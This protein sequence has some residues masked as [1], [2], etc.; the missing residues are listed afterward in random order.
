MLYKISIACLTAARSLRSP[1]WPALLSTVPWRQL[2]HSPGS[3]SELERRTI[4][5]PGPKRR[6]SYVESEAIDSRDGT[7]EPRTVGVL[8][9]RMSAMGG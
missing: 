9:E 1:P 3:F 2:S 4:P 7:I 8:P 5:S 6:D